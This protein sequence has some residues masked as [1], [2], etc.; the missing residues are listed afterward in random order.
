MRIVD[1]LLRF[2]EIRRAWIGV[3]VEPVEA[4]PWGR[5]RGVR[6]SRVAPGS[7]AALAGLSVGDRLLAAN[8]RPLTGPLDFEGVMLDLRAGDE[9]ELAVEGRSRT[10]CSRPSPTRRSPPSA[11]A[12]CRTSRRSRSRRRC[13]RSAG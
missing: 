13:A 11:C 2:G 4:D 8:R 9:L 3:D 12:C 1:D 10:S 5:T 7:P 6:V